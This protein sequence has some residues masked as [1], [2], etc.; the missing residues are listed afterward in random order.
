MLEYF[1]KGHTYSNVYFL[2]I[3]ASG[4]STIVSSNPSDLVDKFFD[5]FEDTVSVVVEQNRR[6]TGCK[7]A[8]F[9]GWQ[10]DGG[11]CMFYDSNESVSQHTVLQCAID[12][13]N[14]NLNPLKT[15]L[16]RLGV[17]GEF[18][19]RIAIH[20]GTFT[21]KGNIK[22][23]SI[24][25]KELNLV[26]HLET[27]TPKDS[28]TIPQDLLDRCP[29]E[30]VS[31]FWLL[32]FEYNGRQ[33]AIYSNRL[34]HEIALEWIGSAP[35][36][37]SVSVNLL[38][39]RYSEKDKSAIIQFAQSE[40][41]DIGTAL[42]TCSQYLLSTARP[43]RYRSVVQKLTSEGIKY[44]CLA[45]NPE[46]EIA[47]YYAQVRGEDELILKIKTSTELMKKFAVSL[48]KYSKNFELYHYNSLPHFGGLMIDRQD[49]GIFLYAPY[50]PNLGHTLTIE[51]AD[52]PHIAVF[53]S[54]CSNLIHQVNAYIDA[55]FIDKLTIRII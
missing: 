54:K 11:L 13:L 53:S 26:S 51:R 16:H 7:Y 22:R 38:A 2:K 41:I 47:E 45:L 36:A 27:I 28:V 33:I 4:H 40:I 55:I 52:S 1:K 20:S 9:W 29:K 44:K 12:L 46:C 32:P 39:R 34:R 14:N 23:G 37:E 31:D 10:G 24:H 49:N 25:S 19:V 8:G 42:S 3:D 17:S 35:I 48:G 21:Y 5:H 18:H 43:A 6:L 50:L 30:L 15:V